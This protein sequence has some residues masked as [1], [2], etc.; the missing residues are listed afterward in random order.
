M[1]LNF[2][3]LTY[4]TLKNYLNIIYNLKVLNYYFRKFTKYETLLIRGTHYI[5]KFTKSGE[6]LF[7]KSC[8]K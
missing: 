2:T 7:L 1:A 5:W 4:L 3:K 8:Y 6:L